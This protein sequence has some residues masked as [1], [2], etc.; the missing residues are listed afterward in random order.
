[1]TFDNLISFGS[2]FVA[3]ISVYYSQRNAKDQNS[4][5]DRTFTVDTMKEIAN[6]QI[7]TYRTEMELSK[8]N[9]K[10]AQEELTN[11]L[12][13]L[14]EANIK[15]Q[16]NQESIRKMNEKLH[17]LKNAS[18]Q[19]KEYYEKQISQL[20]EENRQLKSRCESLKTE[21]SRY[22]KGVK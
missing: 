15:L 19:M 10:K 6:R 14:R 16:Q 13:R 11:T 8:E 9:Q 20:K 17:E 22:K 4:Q 3:G 1:M 7:D 21:L 18:I 12:D 5:A 2:F